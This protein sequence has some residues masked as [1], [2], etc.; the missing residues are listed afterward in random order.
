MGI[1][2]QPS[3]E[4]ESSVLNGAKCNRQS[5]VMFTLITSKDEN[6]LL[7]AQY[8]FVSSQDCTHPAL[9]ILGRTADAEW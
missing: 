7:V 1:A 9:K 6:V 2:S 8:T 4:S 5:G 3:V